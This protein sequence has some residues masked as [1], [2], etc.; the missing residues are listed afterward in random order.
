MRRNL[1]VLSVNDSQLLTDMSSETPQI[2][3]SR[4][5]IDCRR[6]RAVVA[7]VRFICTPEGSSGNESSAAEIERHTQR[8]DSGWEELS[9]PAKLMQAV[10]ANEN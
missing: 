6:E 4:A 10:S 1:I 5:N 9:G 3:F 8:C 2:C 7:I